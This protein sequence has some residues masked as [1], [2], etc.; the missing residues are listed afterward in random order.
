RD[1]VRQLEVAMKSGVLTRVEARFYLAKNLR[2]HER[3]YARAIELLTPLV[4]QYPR[5]AVFRLLIGDLHA[6]LSHWPEAAEHF[7]IAESLVGGST[8][9]PSD[10]NN[11]CSARV[12]AVAQQA[13]TKLPKQTQEAKR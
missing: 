12:R 10:R 11:A 6:K 9:G 5:N 8:S 3:D 4:E 2:N 7:R 13:L 1:G